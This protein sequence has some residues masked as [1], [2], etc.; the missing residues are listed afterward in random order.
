MLL[1]N[2]L[3]YTSD[4]VLKPELERI[5]LP[6]EDQTLTDREKIRAAA[7]AACELMK[8]GMQVEMTDED[9]TRA[10]DIFE[11]NLPLTTP[12]LH[13]PAV[14]LKLEALL[15]EYD[16]DLISDTTRLRRYITNKLIEESHG[17]NPPAQRLKALELLG[18]ITEVGLFTERSIIQVQ[19]M[20]TSE[21]EQSLRQTLT[22]LLNPTDYKEVKN[23]EEGENG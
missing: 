6:S 3:N 19:N 5:P 4:G 18:K 21:L 1:N 17:K 13:N 8:A 9:E 20:P 10:F 23:E 7:R 22:V 16:H 2:L 14:T 12:D 15:T 11:G